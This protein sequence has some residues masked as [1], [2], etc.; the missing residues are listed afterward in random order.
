MNAA[1]RTLA[2]LT[3]TAMVGLAV[4]ASLQRHR[5]RGESMK[6]TLLPGETVVSVAANRPLGILR[7]PRVG[8]IAII[9]LP[10]EHDLI[11][12]KRLVAGP[13]TAWGGGGDAVAAG[14]GWV[15]VGDHPVLSTDSRHHGRVPSESIVGIVV[16]RVSDDDGVSRPA[17]DPRLD[18]PAVDPESV[19]G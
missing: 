3:A 17:R 14:P 4:G 8:D 5:V 13:G 11:G 19:D 12:I 15:A 2:A 6:P 9:R 7:R 10:W 16:A 1:N 18:Q